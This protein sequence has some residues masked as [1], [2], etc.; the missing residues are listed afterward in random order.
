MTSASVLIVDDDR[1]IVRLC[2]RLLERASYEVFASTDP[3]EAL[4][5]L[6]ARK[7]DLLLA[8]IRMP[9]MDGFELI[10]RS[11]GIQPDLAVLVMT[12]FGTVDTAVQALYKGV[13]GLILK[14]FENTADL[15]QAVQ[16]V[17]FDSRQKQDAARAQ[18]LRPLFDIS[19]TFIAE[20]SLEPLEKLI[21]DAAV[22]NFQAKTI[23]VYMAVA[24]TKEPKLIVQK[25][26]PDPIG[27]PAW[28]QVLRHAFSLEAGA[29]INTTGSPDA[30][31]QPALRSLGWA[32]IIISPVLRNAQKFFFIVG[33]E[34]KQ[35]NFS[36]SELD[37]FTIFAR[38]SVVAME[39]ARL[40]TDLKEYVRKVEESQRALIQAEKMAAVGRLMSSLAHEINNPLQSV[41]NCV[42]LAMRE[43]VN[44]EKR[45]G[46]LTMTESELERLVNTVRHMLDFYR[47][48]SIAKES[49]NLNGIIERVVH[50]LTPQLNDSNVKIDIKFEKSIPQVYGVRDQLQQVFF[51][52]ILNSMDEVEKQTEKL[53]WL[54]M[55][56]NRKEV[57]ITIEDSGQGIDAEVREHIFEPFVSSKETGT[58]LGL[59]ISYSIIEAHEGRLSLIPGRHGQGA[60]FE[61]R[62]PI[63]REA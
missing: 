21:L 32:S 41:R 2:Q 8:D 1:S 37:L 24:G 11:R 45:S 6:D 19:E 25:D 22:N 14:P 60:C 13:D 42:H 20:T 10:E 33:R 30:T 17:L 23:S 44:E 48:G 50:L 61:I 51:N 52:L 34:A 55:T 49:V 59:S 9:V 29:V 18:A 43:D 35:N 3:L 16:R 54:D 39:N 38:Q 46:Y 53:I 57:I 12:G 4:K 31:L 47:P 5:I 27:S 26:T 28:A 36:D 56:R 40:Y 62:I 7:I 63:E 58:G 15:V